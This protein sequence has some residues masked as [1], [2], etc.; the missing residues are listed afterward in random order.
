MSCLRGD[1]DGPRPLYHQ[2]GDGEMSGRNMIGKARLVSASPFRASVKMDLNE[3]LNSNSDDE[4]VFDREEL[5]ELLKTRESPIKD[6][7]Q[8]LRNTKTEFLANFDANQRNDDTMT[9]RSERTP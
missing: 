5:P 6:D 1:L 7:S 4:D 8:L 3:N 2:E 9:N